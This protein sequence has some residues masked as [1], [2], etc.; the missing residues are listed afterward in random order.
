MTEKRGLLLRAAARIFSE[1]GFHAAKV[2]EITAEAGVAQGTFYLYFP[3]KEAIFVELMRDFAGDLRLA[4]LGFS[5]A[6]AV[7]VEDVADRLH[8]LL[9]DI[10]TVCAAQS[11]VAALFFA[12]APAVS[13][14]AGA[15]RQQFLIEA[16][17]ITAGYLDDGISRGHVRPL[18]V[19]TVARA[20]VGY[21]LYTV[22]RT[23]LG[24]GRRE[25]LDELARE[26]LEFELY[27]ILAVGAG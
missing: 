25:N 4:A 27:G 5:W 21:V 13:E 16:E 19:E 20:V 14:E 7:T 6:D 8:G 17:Q 15:I 10:F 3:S 9:V 2:S 26:L 18:D 23:I 1:R 11:E 12:A 22:T 24:E